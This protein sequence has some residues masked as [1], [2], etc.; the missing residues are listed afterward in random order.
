MPFRDEIIEARFVTDGI[1]TR[2][3][4]GHVV[5]CL[6]HFCNVNN[7]NFATILKLGNLG[8]LFVFSAMGG[9]IEFC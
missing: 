3:G 5:K 9:G 4:I 1:Y 6:K 8:N 2:F 7:L